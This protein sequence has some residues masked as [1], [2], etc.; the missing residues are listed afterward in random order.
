M[1]A[2]P[3][4]TRMIQRVGAAAVVGAAALSAVLVAATVKPLAAAPDAFPQ[5]MAVANPDEPPVRT[6]SPKVLPSKD[7]RLPPAYGPNTSKVLVIVYSD[8][9]CP[10][11]RRVTAATE[12]I[13]EEWPGEVRVEFRQLPLAMHRN[14]EDAAV[15]SLA[16]HRQGKFW[17]MHDLLF[18][19]QGALD[20]DS[21]RAYARQ[22]GLDMKR[23]EKD[24]ADPALRRRVREEAA[25]ANRLGGTSTPSFLINGKLY[26][27]WGSWM[28]FRSYVEQELK[29]VNEIL[30]TGTKLRDVHALRARAAIQDDAALEAYKAGV[31][32]PLARAKPASAPRRDG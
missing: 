12:Q 16:V 14:A 25:L 18:A 20:P 19:N 7:P 24:Y 17:P 9:Q 30:A 3:R 26:V 13:A 23:Y 32:D 6:H 1:R 8:F 2:V 4:M 28:G 22:L 21:L 11:C 29:A 31:I 15:A 27:G 10:V 5:S